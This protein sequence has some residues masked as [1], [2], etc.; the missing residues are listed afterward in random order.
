MEKLKV[1][2]IAHSAVLKDMGR[3]RY[4]PLAGRDDL[5]VHLVVPKRWYQFGRWID[6]DLPDDPGIHVHVLP[7]WFARAPLVSWYLHVYPGLANLIDELKPDVIHLWEEPWSLVALQASLLRGAA[8]LVLEVDQNII[9]HLRFPFGWI[10]RHVLGDTDYILP[11]S[12]D[13]ETV[14]RS[15]GYKGPASFIE[16]G[17]DQSTFY[18]T[19]AASSQ[20][21]GLRL[22]YVGRIV[23]EKGLD[24]AIDALALLP[25]EVTLDIMGEGPHEAHLRQR[26]D[27]LGLGDRVRFRGWGSAVEVA[28]FIRAHDIMLL[29]TRTTGAVREQFGRVIIECQAC[30]VPIIGSECGAIPDVT[31]DGGWIV[32]ESNP[33]AL[34]HCI[35][36]I[37]SDPRERRRRADAGRQNV[38]NRFTYEVIANKL[39][40]GWREAAER[41]QS[42]TGVRSRVVEDTRLQRPAVGKSII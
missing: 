11:R 4:Y 34:A 12:A 41:S 22:G 7:I 31:G 19:T 25:V 37:L 10:R 29:L 39:E 14:V 6:A 40:A 33:E 36:S 3:L 5:E 32:P 24:D 8:A 16:Y 38:L 30:G 21:E 2:S 27:E 35:W 1:L 13:A 18:P 26:I 28:D 23:V 42:K 15:F 20:S 9:K 17:V